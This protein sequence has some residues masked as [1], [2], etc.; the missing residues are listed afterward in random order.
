MRLKDHPD[1][2]YTSDYSTSNIK[3]GQ[4]IWRGEIC[5]KGGALFKKYLNNDD[6]NAES[7][8]DGWFKTGDVGTL[9]EN[10]RLQITDRVKNLFKLQQGE[11]ISPEKI[12]GIINT[13]A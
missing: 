9:Y 12:E 8:E 5:L 4:R 13:N 3:D 7:F 6:A 2:E 11:Y 10:G 1:L